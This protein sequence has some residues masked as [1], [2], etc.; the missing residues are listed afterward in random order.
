VGSSDYADF[1]V[2]SSPCGETG[3]IRLQQRNKSGSFVVCG[4]TVSVESG[5]TILSTFNIPAGSF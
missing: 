4:V 1:K 3:S 2:T 5:F